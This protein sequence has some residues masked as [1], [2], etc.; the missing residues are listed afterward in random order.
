MSI[1]CAEQPSRSQ[2]ICKYYKEKMK[3]Q[4]NMKSMARYQ[5]PR[6]PR[7]EPL[8]FSLPEFSSFRLQ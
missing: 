5:A 2:S 8:F 1:M 3:H 7:Y 4:A 6:A